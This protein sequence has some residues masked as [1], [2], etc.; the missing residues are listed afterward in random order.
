MFPK[1]IL[2]PGFLTVMNLFLGFY[3]I[4]LAAG[5]NFMMASWLIILAAIFDAFDGK[6]A[7]ATKSFSQF[8]IE[9]DSLADVV[10]FGVAPSFL[11]YKV[12]LHQMGPAGLVISF[13][14]LVF[15]T[16]RL[17]RFNVHISGFDKTNFQGLPIPAAAGT[18]ASF[19][20]FNYYFWN[21]LW[22]PS[23]ILPLVVLVSLLM[24]STIPFDAMPKFSFTK[25]RKNNVLLS[26]LIVSATLVVFFPN[27]A[28][29]P[30][31]ITYIL[32][33]TIR[34]LFQINRGASEDEDSDQSLD[35]DIEIILARRG[36]N[37]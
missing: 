30:L 16:I 13:F 17:A 23:L 19:I 29:F 3:S 15:G 36:E 9:F 31:A 14:P 35:E 8:G 7:R 2:A 1:R 10:S 21:E 27:Q 37:N 22:M 32:Y 28:I 33:S 20:T 24:V 34:A 11:I 25:G 6:V 12:N 26:L 4:I 18:L 5:E